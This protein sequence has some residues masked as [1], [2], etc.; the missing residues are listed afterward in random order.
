MLAQM[1]RSP[2]ENPYE[3]DHPSW[4]KRRR[5]KTR[6]WKKQSPKRHALNSVAAVHESSFSWSNIAHDRCRFDRK[7]AG[8][9]LATFRQDCWRNNK[10][11]AKTHDSVHA[12]EHACGVLTANRHPKTLLPYVCINLQTISEHAPHQ[13]LHLCYI[14]RGGVSK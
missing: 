11:T 14:I 8:A 13:K 7:S 5:P 10:R 3:R 2:A 4:P 1:L 12:L 9:S 6:E